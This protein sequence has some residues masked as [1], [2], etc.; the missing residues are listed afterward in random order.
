MQPNGPF[1]LQMRKWDPETVMHWTKVIQP[2]RCPVGIQSQV[3]LQVQGSFQDNACQCG[4]WLAQVPM[5]SGH[6][7]GDFNQGLPT[8]GPVSFQ[9]EFSPTRQLHIP[10]LLHPQSWLQGA[11]SGWVHVGREAPGESTT[12][13]KDKSWSWLCDC[14][15]FANWARAFVSLHRLRH[16]IEGGKWD[17]LEL[18][19]LCAN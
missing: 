2:V 13:R 1:G 3:W 17:T 11:Q 12:R 10:F 15:V 14:T 8:P 18:A 16:W 9:R 7:S 6:E 5:A 4:A 19:L